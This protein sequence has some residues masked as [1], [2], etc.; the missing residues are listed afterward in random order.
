MAYIARIAALTYVV[1]RLS[2]LRPI[3]APSPFPN[4]AFGD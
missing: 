2:L 3:I 1:A 4:L